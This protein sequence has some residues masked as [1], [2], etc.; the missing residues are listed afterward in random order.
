[1]LLD[2]ALFNTQHDKLQT[3]GKVE[4]SKETSWAH[5]YTMVK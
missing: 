1:M 3:R 4:L 2:A 5:P